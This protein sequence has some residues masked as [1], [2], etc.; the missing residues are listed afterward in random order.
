[1]AAKL[2]I[3]TPWQVKSD[4][5]PV[6]I[7]LYSF[8]HSNIP[9]RR[10]RFPCLFCPVWIVLVV[11]NLPHGSWAGKIPAPKSFTKSSKKMH[12]STSIW[13]AG[14]CKIPRCE[15]WKLIVIQ[16]TQAVERPCHSFQTFQPGF[17]FTVIVLITD[18]LGVPCA[19]AQQCG[20]DWI[21]I[22]DVATANSVLLQ[23]GCMILL[24]KVLLDG[25]IGNWRSNSSNFCFP[26]IPWHIYGLTNFKSETCFCLVASKRR[27]LSAPSPY[28]LT[29]IVLARLQHGS[30]F[31]A[32][33][34][35]GNQRLKRYDMMNLTFP[36]F[37]V[38][39]FHWV[40]KIWAKS[41]I[42]QGDFETTVCSFLSPKMLKDPG[43]PRS[44]NKM[45]HVHRFESWPTPLWN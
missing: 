18:S 42:G 24:S 12:R 14:I 19:A 45:S 2:S 35:I 27:W 44:W 34:V 1:M 4:S 43:D 10:Y 28:S 21:D 39:I 38:F 25:H 26:G 30:W 40:T 33:H 23:L 7:G 5:Q 36:V 17:I 31:S 22:F 29:G 41:P 20:L 6:L 37:T 13:I 16:S 3:G 11:K 8:Q 9:L 32:L 15:Y